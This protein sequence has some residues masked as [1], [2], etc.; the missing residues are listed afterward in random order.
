MKLPVAPPQTHYRFPISES[1]RVFRV[2]VGPGVGRN[3]PT[4]PYRSD[5]FQLL[6][7]SVQQD[8]MKWVTFS[9]FSLVIIINI[10]QVKVYART[11]EY[12]RFGAQHRPQSTAPSSTDRHPPS[13]NWMLLVFLPIRSTT[14]HLPDKTISR[15]E[16]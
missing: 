9:Y 13:N 15:L 4:G 11:R 1:G 8:L 14:V 2:V 5:K 7:C 3:D 10:A 16:L 6:S 12:L